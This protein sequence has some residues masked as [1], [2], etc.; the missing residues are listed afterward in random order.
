MKKTHLTRKNLIFL[1]LLFFFLFLQAFVFFCLDTNGMMNPKNPIVSMASLFG[2]YPAELITVDYVAFLLVDVYT[3]ILAFALLFEVRLA[4]YSNEK[5]WSKKYIIAYVITVVAYLLLSF[6][7]SILL[8]LPYTL[9]K[10]TFQMGMLFHSLILAL[11]IYLVLGSFVFAV[12][13]LIVNFKN[14]DKP[15]RFFGKKAAMLE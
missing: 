3:F 12:F 2:F 4:K 6:G 1:A 8:Q 14:I 10:F 13:A 7:L 11:V 15:F 5:V 9:D